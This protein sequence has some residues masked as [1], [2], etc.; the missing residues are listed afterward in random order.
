M[1][2]LLLAAC[3]SKAAEG[4][5]YNKIVATT[6]EKL[7]AIQ[8]R[9]QAGNMNAALAVYDFQE[10][11]KDPNYEITWKGS[12]KI[13]QEFNLIDHNNRI[14]EDTRKALNAQK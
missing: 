1:A 14:F 3:S 9:G 8:E 4:P 13:L 7:E 5:D 11:L 6:A 12:I 10:S 2:L